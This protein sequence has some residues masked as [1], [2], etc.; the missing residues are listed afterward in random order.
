M[1]EFKLKYRKKPRK[2]MD[3]D[4]GSP[5]Q[6]VNHI[7][8]IPYSSPTRG[9]ILSCHSDFKKAAVSSSLLNL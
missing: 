2:H 1:R 8:D 7:I 9:E 4:K 6:T 3:I 5:Q